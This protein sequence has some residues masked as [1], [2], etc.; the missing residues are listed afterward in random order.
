M[1]QQQILSTNLED[2]NVLDTKL[3]HENNESDDVSEITVEDSEFQGTDKI[4]IKGKE[5]TEKELIELLNTAIYIE[6]RF[7]AAAGAYFI[8][9]VGQ[10]LLTTTGV[11]ILA[12]VTIKNSHW[13][14]RTIVRWLNAPAAS[15]SR[16]YNIS[17]N[18]PTDTGNVKL[19]LFRDKHGNTPISKK[20]GLFKNGRYTIDKDNAQHGN[21]RWKLKKWQAYSIIRRER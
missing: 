5:Y 11:I 15:I 7:A 1:Q 20:S 9:G 8:P 6:P 2:I 10:I 4:L 16:K 3:S 21:K 14:Y 12:G 13:A 17:R 19:G 18:L